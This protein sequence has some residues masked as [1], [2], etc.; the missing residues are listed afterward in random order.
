MYL[1]IYFVRTY[2]L[3][4]YVRARAKYKED[5]YTRQIGKKTRTGHCERYV[6]GVY[7]LHKTILTYQ[8][9]IRVFAKYFLFS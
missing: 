3:Y 2:I 1:F 9:D 5:L 8:I 6:Q 4:T 7:R